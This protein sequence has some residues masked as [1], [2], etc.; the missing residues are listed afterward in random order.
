MPE[1]HDQILGKVIV[2]RTRNARY[3]RLGVTTTGDIKVS[4]PIFTP[5]YFIKNFV[6]KSRTELQN[7][8]HQYRTAYTQPTKIGK[9]HLL[10][11][12]KNA[13]ETNVVYKKPNIVVRVESEDD[14]SS[15]KVQTLIR[16]QVAKAY[17]VEAKAYLPRRVEYVAQHFGFSYSKVRFS[18]A[19]S[20][21]GSCNNDGTISL[22][23]AL[24]KLPF[25]L[26]DYVIIHELAHTKHL[27]HSPE[28]WQQV[29]QCDKNYKVHRK[30]LKNYSPHI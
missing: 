15:E 19:K 23:I 21:W 26:I 30:A 3:V 28:F 8:L 2:S 5:M 7:M 9:S 10:Q 27:D 18:H 1:F 4:A 14:I 24:M 6:R 12:E 13:P 20:R 29:A 11:I 22:N 16:E 25:E 17:R